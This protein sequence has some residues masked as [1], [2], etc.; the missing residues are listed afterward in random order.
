MKRP[1]ISTHSSDPELVGSNETSSWVLGRNCVYRDST[2]AEYRVSIRTSRGWKSYGH[3]NDLE[4]ATYV[5]NIA[6]LAERCE[7]KYELNEGIGE[8]DRE[9][10]DRWRRQPGNSNLEKTAAERYKNVQADLAA[11]REQERIEAEKAAKERRLRETR[12]AEERKQQEAAAAEKRRIH[13]EKV[14][15]IYGLSNPDL[16]NFIKNTKLHDPLYEIAMNEAVC[17]YNKLGIPRAT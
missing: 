10:L 17:R 9:E 15:M 13:D 11:L 8:K 1:E 5:A 2:I 4:T 12:L 16:V 6:I 3:F 14:R 7:E